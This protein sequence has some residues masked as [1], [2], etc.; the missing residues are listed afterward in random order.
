LSVFGVEAIPESIDSIVRLGID[1]SRLF[2]AARLPAML[3]EAIDLWIY[4][5]SFEHVPDPK[6]H[7]EWVL[8]NSSATASVLLVLPDANSLSDKLLGRW[9]P[10]RIADH[11]FHWSQR[12]LEGVWGQFGFKTVARFHPA[13]CVTIGMLAVHAA[14]KFCVNTFESLALRGPSMFNIGEQGLLL[15]R[16]N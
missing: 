9:W 13:K 5:D 15:R 14:H 10:H 2:D 4:Q 7:L 1:R 16:E 11:V 3:P 8:R 12:G 6:A